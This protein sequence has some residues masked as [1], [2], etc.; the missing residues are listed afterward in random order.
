MLGIYFKHFADRICQACYS[1]SVR[2][3][4]QGNIIT[5]KQIL[6]KW[7]DLTQCLFESKSVPLTL[8]LSSIMLS[9][10]FDFSKILSLITFYWNFVLTE[11]AGRE[12]RKTLADSKMKPLRRDLQIPAEDFLIDVME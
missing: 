4:T 8:L 10:I 6:T 2:P 9:S 5:N 12:R 3:M 11:M 7:F 1:V